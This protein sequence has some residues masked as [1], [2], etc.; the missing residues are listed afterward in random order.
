[1]EKVSEASS[2]FEKELEKVSWLKALEEKTKIPKTLILVG[3]G[4]GGFIFCY[5]VIGPALLC[6]L[7]GFVYPAYASFRAIET[8]EKEDD[9]QWL[10]Y[11]VIYAIFNLIETFVDMILFWFPFYYSFK[12]GLLIWLFLPNVRG[13]QYVY[14]TVVNPLFQKHIANT[15]EGNEEKKKDK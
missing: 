14:T 3:T 4:L 2:D 9:T 15:P 11:W 5:V 1:M 7:V 13:A 8:E 6:N 12:F 10:T